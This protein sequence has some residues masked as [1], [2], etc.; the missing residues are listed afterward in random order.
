M[1]CEH[2]DLSLCRSALSTSVPCDLF[3]DPAVL[4]FGEEILCQTHTGKPGMEEA[5]LC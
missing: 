3:G 2:R 1:G 5:C 4:W